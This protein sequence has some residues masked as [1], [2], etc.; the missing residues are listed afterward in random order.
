MAE[1]ITAEYL[2]ALHSVCLNCTFININP[3]WFIMMALLY[4]PSA[5][6]CEFSH[7]FCSPEEGVVEEDED[8]DADMEEDVIQ[9]IK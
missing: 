8:S 1:F 5:N 3:I 4:L 9:P 2:C 6:L 7:F